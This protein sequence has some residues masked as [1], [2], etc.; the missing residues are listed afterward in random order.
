[1]VEQYDFSGYATKN[2]LLCTDGRTIRQDAFKECDGVTVPLLW[3]HRHDDPSY[4]LGHARLEN[5]KDGVYMYGKFNDTERAQTCKKVLE[6]NDLKGLSI[7]ARGLKQRAGDVLHGVI[8]E[9]SLVLSGANPGATIDYVMSHNDDEEDEL[10]MYL[11][12]DEY[13]ELKHGDIEVEFPEPIEVTDNEEKETDM[14]KELMHADEE[15]KQEEKAPAK[16]KKN[17]DEET[18]EDVIN[19]LTDKQKT[20]M[21]A[22]LAA[23]D[24]ANDDDDEEDEDEEENKSMKHNAFE[25]YEDTETTLTHADMEEIFRDAKKLGSL[26]DAV[27]EHMENGVL[28]HADSDY[29]IERGTGENTYFV[30]DPEMLFP[31]FRNVNGATPEFF[32]RDTTWVTDFMASVKHTPFARIKTMIADITM[33]DARALGYVKGNVKKNEFFELIKRTTDPQTVYKKQKMDRDDVVDITDFDVVAWIKGE[34]RD[35]LEEEIARACLV[36]D[37]RSTQSDDKILESH[38]RPVL[39]DHELFTIKTTFDV[40]EAESVNAKNFVKTAIKARKDYKGT[41]NPVMYITDTMLADLLT[42]E[43]GNGRFIYESETQLTTALRVR[44]IVTVPV[45]ENITFTNAES[46]TANLAAI[47]INPI[48][49]V[50]GADKGGAVNM[51][52]DFDINYNQMLYLIETRI[53]GALV[54]PKS[55]IVIGTTEKE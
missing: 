15:E 46:K 44:K 8:K 23:A 27:E 32:K 24:E 31:D 50:I 5:R 28:S 47:I 10:Y 18:I 20:A 1:M 19:T 42:M 53:S 48:D 43:D 45:F 49:Y 3:N 34:M 41:G 40:E 12:G 36:G 14:A 21:Y 35:M 33:D 7:H 6:H 9:V 38:I 29:G 55:A 25:S 2:D 17:E 22:L 13:T 39:T 51:F 16:E 30:R 37:G 4:V 54:K 11:I 52:D 26:R